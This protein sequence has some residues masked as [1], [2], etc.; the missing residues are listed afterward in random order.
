M[1]QLLFN[2]FLEINKKH[3]NNEYV[4]IAERF[5][6]I[7]HFS[8]NLNCQELSNM[9][10]SYYHFTKVSKTV[11]KHNSY[12][13]LRDAA[14]YNVGSD[15]LF[16]YDLR[17]DH[18]I[19]ILGNFMIIKKDQL[20]DT[21]H[22]SK[23]EYNDYIRGLTS[24]KLSRKYIDTAF[25]NLLVFLKK[26]EEELGY[27]SLD[28]YR[29][30]IRDKQGILYNTESGKEILA[31]LLAS[32]NCGE[33]SW[34]FGLNQSDIFNFLGDLI[35]IAPHILS[36]QLANDPCFMQLFSSDFRGGNIKTPYELLIRIIKKEFFDA[37][38]SQHP[39][40]T[41]MHNLLDKVGNSTVEQNLFSYLSN[42][43]SAITTGITKQAGF[44]VL[45]H[46]IAGTGKTELSKVIAEISGKPIYHLKLS[47][48]DSDS[49][50]QIDFL[51]K[52]LSALST[53]AAIF[54]NSDFILLIDECE[55]LFENKNAQKE[56]I[57]SVLEC[58]QVPCIFI[59]NSIK[60]FHPAYLRRFHYH[61]NVDIC[62]YNQ[63]I[64][65]IKNFLS[66]HKEFEHLYSE[67]IIDY[68]ATNSITNADIHDN[69][70]YYNTT[71]N[72]NFLCQKVSNQKITQDGL[73]LNN[74]EQSMYNYIYP[75]NNQY[76]FDSILGYEEEKELLL[77]LHHYLLNKEKYN[78][79]NAHVPHGSILYGSP[80]TGKTS[81][82]KALAK[83]CNLPILVVSTGMM[84][85]D[86]N[87]AL[88][89]KKI[90]NLA[91]KSGPGI[92][93]LDEF[94]KMAL[95]RKLEMKNG[96]A[97][98][99]MNQLLIE[100]DG[101][102]KNNLDIFIYAT[103]NTIDYIDPAISRSGRLEQIVEIGLPPAK[104]RE[105]MLKSL[106]GEKIPGIK[107]IVQ[108]TTGCSFIDL[109]SIVN[110]YKI[111][112]IRNPTKQSKQSLLFKAIHNFS[113]GKLTTT[114]LLEKEKTLVAYHES[115][116]AFMAYLFGRGVGNI[117]I[118]P[119][120]GSLGTTLMLH[121]ETKNLRTKRDLEHELMIL[122]AGRAAENIFLGTETNGSSN[123]FKQATT[124]AMGNLY[125][126][127]HET[128]GLI[129]PNMKEYSIFSEGYRVK[130]ESAVNSILAQLYDRTKVILSQSKEEVESIVKVLMRKEEIVQPEMEDI[131]LATMKI[132]NSTKTELIGLFN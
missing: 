54:K 82:I 2:S 15:I 40:E 98:S 22:F 8:D 118:I 80:G 68:I 51:T 119:K 43:L 46:G 97:Q 112:L 86:S 49:K 38:I 125:I 121:D 59:A 17:E 36:S 78:Q 105:K 44:K 130:V 6:E 102:Y 113:L 48:T 16:N 45:L 31:Q 127:A 25:E 20:S 57:T 81:I 90:F 60:E 34:Q 41:F 28:T 84:T 11:I 37:M 99:L 108:H 120:S 65:V 7:F 1:N 27:S 50:K 55:E 14:Q 62:D 123:D 71:G 13:R 96:T 79:L 64:Y 21:T 3:F 91:K 23:E 69:M 114:T 10:S 83:K 131:L 93:L 109:D 66:K 107:Q 75:E 116:H 33:L 72:Y 18:N 42:D 128:I 115:G 61:L 35:G 39:I 19:R 76:Y 77:G 26:W 52:T 129:Y 4:F 87:G 24:R 95:N 53:V 12:Y 47:E 100:M 94:E 104:V 74:L 63:K 110:N 124:L 88:Q 111:S 5:A 89:I 117:S 103:C 58:L 73:Q 101:I 32:Y 126:L 106:L 29:E 92:I 122:M 9:V 132:K 56:K 30:I 70:L 67:G 85:N